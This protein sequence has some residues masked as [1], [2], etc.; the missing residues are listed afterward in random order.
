MSLPTCNLPTASPMCQK[1]PPHLTLS[2]HPPVFTPS[3]HSHFPFLMSLFCSLQGSYTLRWIPVTFVLW[4]VPLL[5]IPSGEHAVLATFR[6][7]F[8]LPAARL[9]FS[10]PQTVQVPSQLT[11]CHF[12]LPFLAT[13]W[14][15]QQQALPFLP[16]LTNAPHALNH[17]GKSFSLG[18]L[19]LDLL[20]TYP[21][22]FAPIPLRLL[23]NMVWF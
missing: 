23:A 20:R 13:Q 16:F 11:N 2:F 7:H 6:P 3:C 19:S 17:E 4:P 5:A 18:Q 22:A 9:Y 8:L 1:Q 21:S 12:Q 14:P 10:L 15:E